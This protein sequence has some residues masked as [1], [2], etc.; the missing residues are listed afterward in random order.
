MKKWNT[1]EM[2]ELAIEYTENNGCNG[3]T[4]DASHVNYKKKTN[5][6]ECGHNTNFMFNR[7]CA[8]SEN[9]TPDSLS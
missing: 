1:P 3:E 6:C 4:P 9:H 5:Q 7:D 8:D 2:V